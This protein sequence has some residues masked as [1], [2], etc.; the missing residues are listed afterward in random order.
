MTQND[1]IPENDPANPQEGSD[2]PEVID[3]AEEAEGVAETAA[4]AEAPAAD[5]SAEIEALKAEVQ[6]YKDE[7]LRAHAEMENV[8]R[9]AEQEVSK[10]RKFAVQ[11]FAKDLLSVAD[12]LGRALSAVPEEARETDDA[13]KNLMLGVEMTE[14]ELLTVFERYKVAKV[15]A[16]GAPFDVRNGTQPSEFVLPVQYVVTEVQFT[17]R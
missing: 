16:L 12:N 2:A 7:F 4:E 5:S 1:P 15:D 8:R 10:A 17:R 6:K 13:V 11:D 3:G 14:K 9:R